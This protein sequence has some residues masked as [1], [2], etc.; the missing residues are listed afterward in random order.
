M[1]RRAFL[2]VT[3][4]LFHFALLPAGAALAAESEGEAN[5]ETYR[6]QSSLAPGR[7]THVTAHI[8]VTGKLRVPG[9]DRL[10]ELPLRVA[11]DLSYLETMLSTDALAQ[12]RSARVYDK[13]EAVIEIAQGEVKPR[14]HPE[15]RRIVAE[16]VDGRGRLY[17]PDGPLT[18]DQ[19]DLIQV[20]GDT[21]TVPHLL[22]AEE[23]RV[24][25]RWRHSREGMQALLGLDACASSEVFSTLDEV[26][27]G[28]G[29][30][31]LEGRVDGAAAGVSTELEVKARYHFDLKRERITALN[32]AVRETRDI[33]HVAPGMDVVAK[34]RLRLTPSEA[35]VDQD[36]LAGGDREPEDKQLRLVHQSDDCGL[37]LQYDRRWH[38][39]ADLPSN[40]SL[41]LIDRGEL[42]SQCNLTP[43]KPEIATQID[44]E[45]FRGQVRKTLGDHFDQFSGSEQWTDGFGQQV[46]RVVAVG[47]TE[48]LPIVWYYYLIRGEGHALSAAITVEASLTKGF[49]RADRDLVQGLRLIDPNGSGPKD[50]PARRPEGQRVA[51]GQKAASGG[52]SQKQ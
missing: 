29:R 15:R 12:R 10:S 17:C 50:R 27:D 25:Q 5:A 30:I 36:L 42:V 37:L 31:S 47:Q 32:L 35:A 16:V 52:K 21:L 7:S 23:V 34:L 4:G 20:V 22:P 28:I 46:L 39:T 26:G 44:L 11:G 51:E 19:L 40:V 8:E 1:K 49:G 24:G 13:A 48:G 6:L 33:G 3:I 18:R 14:L 45:K 9:K 2:A 41:R 38:V 43:V